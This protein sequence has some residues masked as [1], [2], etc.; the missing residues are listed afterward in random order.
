MVS[1]D[2]LL[3]LGQHLVSHHQQVEGKKKEDG[4][5]ESALGGKSQYYCVKRFASFAYTYVF[6]YTYGWQ[7]RGIF[8]VKCCRKILNSIHIDHI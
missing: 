2:L 1:P 3:S 7:Y 4:K 6:A 8:P 5:L